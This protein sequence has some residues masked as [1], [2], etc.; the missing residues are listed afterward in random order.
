MVF[1]DGIVVFRQS[2][3]LTAA[4]SGPDFSQVQNLD[5]D[6]GPQADRRIE[7]EESAE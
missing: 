5:M 6:Q 4:V 7:A 1:R 2:E 3:N